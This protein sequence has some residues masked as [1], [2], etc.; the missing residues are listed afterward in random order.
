MRTGSRQIFFSRGGD[1]AGH[2]AA[3][4]TDL[5]P[6][7][8]TPGRLAGPRPRRRRRGEP[9]R[10]AR[11]WPCAT[12]AGTSRPAGTGMAAVRAAREFEPDAVVLDMMLPDFDGLE[13]LRR[14]R[15]R[16][17]E[18]AGAVPHRQGR[19]RGPRRRAHRR[20]RRL[21][22]QA[23]QPRGGRRP[24][25]RA[26][27][28]HRDHRPTRAA[29]PLLVVGDLTLD[30]DSHEVT[31]GG[32]Q[33]APDRHRVRAAALPH[34]QPQAGAVQGADP[35]PRLELRLRR[36]G[37]RRRALHLLPAQEDRRRPRADDPHHARRRLRAQAR[38]T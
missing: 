5:R 30:E 20:R 10:A 8:A 34:A 1:T 17:P 16:Q 28:A 27:A 38:P 7:P 12:R 23:V 24:A 37:Q 14:M 15:A 11:A 18:R 25:A 32:E 35:R 19:R 3:D 4:R 29:T 22:D 33:I 9:H 2:D 36:P 13:V 31:R 26:A 6:G 21:R